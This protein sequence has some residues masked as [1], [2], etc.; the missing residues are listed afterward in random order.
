MHLG[1]LERQIVSALRMMHHSS[2]R[3]EFIGRQFTEMFAVALQDDKSL[4]RR[5]ER[6]RAQ[7]DHP[8]S[9]IIQDAA[10]RMTRPS[11]RCTR[12]TE[13]CSHQTSSFT[14]RAAGH[15]NYIDGRFACNGTELSGV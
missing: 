12:R 10:R 4:T 1:W 7:E 14:A 11:Q 8:M 9:I 15:Y 2:E 6:P 5:Q 13:G 3:R